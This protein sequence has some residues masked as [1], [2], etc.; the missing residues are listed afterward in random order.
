MRFYLKVVF[1]LFAVF[2]LLYNPLYANNFKIIFRD[3]RISLYRYGKRIECKNCEFIKSGTY[4]KTYRDSLIILKLKDGYLKL[5][6]YSRLLLKENPLLLYGK[7]QISKNRL[8]ENV[9]YSIYPDPIAGGTVDI[10]IGRVNARKNPTVELVNGK[11]KSIK[12]QKL[13]RIGKYYK[14]LLSLPLELKSELY[15]FQIKVYSHDNFTYIKHPFYVKRRKIK[16]GIVRLN[17]KKTAILVTDSKRKRKESEE[18]VNILRVMYDK[19][20]WHGKFRYPVKKPRMIS[21]FGKK[22]SYYSGEKLLFE[23]FHR[24]VDFYGRLGDPVFSPN[25]GLVVLSKD[26]MLTGRTIV[27][28]HGL[29]VFSVFFHLSKINKYVGDWVNKGDIIGYIGSSGIAESSHLHWGVFVNGNYV[30]PIQWTKV[31][32]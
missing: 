1:I 26:R 4:I 21:S 25:S 2:V 17:R 28:N 3:G 12:Q 31:E 15:N 9:S 22:R 20:Y 18:F 14:S 8:F 32:F 11:G 24:G 30:D 23:R 13:Y 5:F 6:P 29:G 16:K 19:Q 7:F 10:V 27:I